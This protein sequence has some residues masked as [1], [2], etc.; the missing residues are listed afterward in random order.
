MEDQPIEVVG[1][2]AKGQFRL[3]AGEADGA[4]EQVEPVF[5]MREDMLNM[6]TDRRGFLLWLPSVMQEF[7]D[8][9]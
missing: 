8:P 1:Q 9:Y 4:D 3:S 6:R 7:S 5:L 2:V